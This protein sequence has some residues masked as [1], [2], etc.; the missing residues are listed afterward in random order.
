MTPPLQLVHLDA[1]TSGLGRRIVRSPYFPIVAQVLTLAVAAYLAWNGLGVGQG[2][3]PDT[4]KVLRKTSLTTLAV[5]GLWWP[6]MILGALVLGR[7]W[8]MVCPMEL[9]NRVS[10]ALARAAGWPG[11]RMPRWLRA[12]WGAVLLYGVLQVLVAGAA[13]H[14][15]PHSTSVMLL[16]LGGA[17]FATGLVFR[18][19]R[20]FCRGLCPATSLLST[21]G[22]FTPIQLSHRSSAICES[23]ETRD[24][25]RPALRDRWDRRSCPSLIRPFR[26]EPSDGC[27]ACLQCAKV[28]PHGNIGYGWVDPRATVRSLGLLRPAE[29]VFIAIATG[30]VAHEVIGEVAWLEDYFHAVPNWMASLAPGVGFGWFE[31]AWFLILFPGLLWG[32]VALMGWALGVRRDLRRFLLAAASG[33]APVVAVAHLAKAAAKAMAWAG[34]LPLAL[35]EPQGLAS[36][37]AIRSHAIPAPEALLSLPTV[38]WFSGL[39]LLVIGLRSLRWLRSLSQE[40]ALAARTGLATAGLLFLGVMATWSLPMS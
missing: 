11:A 1:L 25:V 37:D 10:E 35:R 2:A 20:A 26:R 18:D 28:C 36:L 8:C 27:V 40:E 15:M 30:F 16:V 22:R 12:G 7:T 24:C 6:G 39:L 23:C 32:L 29:A 17:A 31:A 3:D 4:L 21:Y 38:G 5:W 34:Y 9:L 19:P 14:R 33:A 13:I